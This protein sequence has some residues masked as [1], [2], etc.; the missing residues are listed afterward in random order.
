MS[1][2]ESKRQGESSLRLMQAET[3]QL[4]QTLVEARQVVDEA[5]RFLMSLG[6]S[7]ADLALVDGRD[8]DRLEEEALDA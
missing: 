1:K 7:D 2:Q 8:F 4:R 6:F 5:T 3:R